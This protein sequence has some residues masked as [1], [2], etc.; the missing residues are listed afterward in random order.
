MGIWRRL[1]AGAFGLACGVLAVQSQ[2]GDIYLG[3]RGGAS[4]LQDSD[5]T[6]EIPG[7]GQIPAELE[8]DPG[9]LAGVAAG[10]EFDSGFAVEGEFTFRQN[11]V[12]QERL[13]G[14][15]IPIDGFIRSYALMANGYY[16]LD[17]GTIFTPYVGAGAGGA[18]LSI[19][20][21]SVG[22]NFRDSDFAFAYQ[23]MGGVAAD[24]TP[25][26]SAGLEYRYFATAGQ[27]FTDSA[28][29]GTVTVDPDYSTHNIL[30]TLTYR[31]Q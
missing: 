10:F 9:W 20:A 19:D 16:R 18:L 29:G 4:L 30:V 1:F 21:D 7:V 26:V 2:A 31:F 13:L 27:E 14:G 8:F 25:R 23:A 6:I 22:G 24:I 3:F 11:G 28:G 17:T 15:I 12:D 5:M